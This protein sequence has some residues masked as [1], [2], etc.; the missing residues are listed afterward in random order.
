M[1]SE[2]SIIGRLQ[3]ADS[4]RGR[5]ARPSIVQVANPAISTRNVNARYGAF[6]AL[7]DVSISA[8]HGEI[9]AIIGPSGCGKSTMV[10]CKA[11]TGSTT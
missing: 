9:T 5:P 3:E 10:R 6:L 1:A 2:L 11:S 7:R 4:G 8:P